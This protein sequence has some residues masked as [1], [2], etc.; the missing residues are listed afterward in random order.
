MKS[1][2]AAVDLRHLIEN[3]AQLS[4]RLPA[5]SVRLSREDLY[6]VCVWEYRRVPMYMCF[7]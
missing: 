4:K 7:H 3:H 6:R 2:Q 5:S 1:E